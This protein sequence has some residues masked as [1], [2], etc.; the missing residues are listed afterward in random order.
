MKTY[1]NEVCGTC[2]HRDNAKCR[3]APPTMFCYESC[4]YSASHAQPEVLHDRPACS[5]YLGTDVCH[6]CGLRAPVGV[7]TRW[8]RGDEHVPVCANCQAKWEVRDR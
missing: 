2:W 4:G 8:P 5:H 3:E 1:K 7:L 6:D